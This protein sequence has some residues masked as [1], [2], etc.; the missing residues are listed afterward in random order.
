MV[1]KFLQMGSCLHE[2]LILKLEVCRINKLPGWAQSPRQTGIYWGHGKSNSYWDDDIGTRTV[3]SHQKKHVMFLA[4]LLWLS[5]LSAGLWTKRLLV[6]FPVRA[7]A[8]VVGQVP[9]WGRARG[10]W[11][12]CI[13]CTSMFLSLFSPLCKKKKKACDGVHC[14]SDLHCLLLSQLM[15]AFCMR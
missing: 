2:G 15:T 4:W 10:N 7:H 13:S 6:W 3:V 12:L 8:W 5:G 9:S 14:W 11:W 1:L